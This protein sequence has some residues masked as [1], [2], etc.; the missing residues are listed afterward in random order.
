MIRRRYNPGTN[1]DVSFKK[2]QGIVMRKISP[3]SAEE[4]HIDPRQ[5]KIYD[6]ECIIIIVRLRCGCS[7]CVDEFTGKKLLKDS[8]VPSDV[9][10]TQIDY[11]V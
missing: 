9:V 1:Y 6:Y 11:E 2:D 3:T 10:P 8:D 4:V 5:C 7:K